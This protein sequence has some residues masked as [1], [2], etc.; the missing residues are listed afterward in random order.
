[1]ATKRK[2]GASWVYTFRR[3]GLLPKPISRSFGN[4]NEGDIF[5]E[6]IEAQLA[7]GVAP[8]GFIKGKNV[9][10]SLDR[11]INEYIRHVSINPDDV[12]KLMII[13]AENGRTL[14]A[15]ITYDWCEDWIHQFKVVRKVRPGTIKKY[16]GALQRCMTWAMAKGYLNTNYLSLLPK[17]YA[18]FSG[19]DRSPDG[20][21]KDVQRDRRLELG[22]EDRVR[23]VILGHKPADKQRII[24]DETMAA[25]Q[26]MFDLAIETAMRMRE[27]YT[28][29]F[30][31]VDLS[32]RTIFLEK[33]KNGSKRQVALS[34]VA[35]TALQTYLDHVAAGTGGMTKATF[36]AA[37][38][39]FPFWDGNK[40][41]REMD[42]TT[43]KLSRKWSKVFEHA[44]L[45]DFHFHDIRHEATSRFFEKTTLSEMRIS[46]ITGHRN[47]ASLDRY[48]NLR[49]SDLANELW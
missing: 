15:E 14:L 30:R 46:K 43:I 29:E 48:A 23:A 11:L 19:R 39:L 37:D 26:C 17:S 1:M 12:D 28:L 24:I 10:D 31:Q 5:A 32:Q 3:K 2:R 18:Q 22:E 27:I 36:H 8:A 33:T 40:H 47:M 9:I 38:I 4:E 20:V 42:R 6:R 44:G 7:D 21:L 13:K 49:G 45:V 16:K 35:V 34:T 41:R 25:Y